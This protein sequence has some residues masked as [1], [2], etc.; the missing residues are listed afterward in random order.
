VCGQPRD[1]DV[2]YLR[3]KLEHVAVVWHSFTTS[4]A[5]KLEQCNCDSILDYLKWRMLCTR[6]RQSGL[7]FLADTFGLI[8][9]F[10]KVR[11]TRPVSKS[12]TQESRNQ[13]SRP[14]AVL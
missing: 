13:G 6:K 10:L 14:N 7:F 2:F 11:L 1:S 8:K 5:C 12:T 9:E 4:D 3:F